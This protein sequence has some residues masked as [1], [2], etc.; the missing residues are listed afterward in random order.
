LGGLVDGE[1]VRAGTIV[2]VETTGGGGWGDPLERE[3]ELIVRDVIEGKISVEAAFTDY[4]AVVLG[5]GEF[6]LYRIDEAATQTR[7][8]AL[9]AAR[10]GPLPVIDR[11]A[12]IA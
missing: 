8:A 7:R 6:G 9:K 1:F 12:D 5:D 2:R 11:G 10:R 3:P 4:G